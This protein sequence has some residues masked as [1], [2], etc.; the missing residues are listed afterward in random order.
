MK[1]K[2]K[3]RKKKMKRKTYWD[4]KS[5]LLMES[6]NLNECR[7]FLIKNALFKKISCLEMQRLREFLP[8]EPSRY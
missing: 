1:L 4:V 7:F 3:M 6:T 8:V 2:K 5:M